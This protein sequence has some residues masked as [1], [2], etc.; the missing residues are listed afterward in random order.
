LKRQATKSSAK[1][2]S[3]FMIELLR[4]YELAPLRRG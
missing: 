3:L 2:P 4:D 1:L